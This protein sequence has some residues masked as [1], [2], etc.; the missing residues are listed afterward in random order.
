MGIFETLCMKLSP[1][2]YDGSFIEP[3]GVSDSNLISGGKP[4]SDATT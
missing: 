4:F 2:G 1:R 3:F